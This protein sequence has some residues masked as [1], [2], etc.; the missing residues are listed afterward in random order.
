MSLS[1][2]DKVANAVCSDYPRYAHRHPAGAPDQ[3]RRA[4]RE[5]LILFRIGA[6]RRPLRSSPHPQR[7]PEMP[8]MSTPLLLVFTGNSDVSSVESPM[9]FPL[10]GNWW[11]PGGLRA[12]IFQDCLTPSVILT[13]K[14][15]L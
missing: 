12:D 6:R 15:S 3:Y 5:L 13:E 1:N 2:A 10:A 11:L 7:F 9:V 14:P 8:I 4:Q